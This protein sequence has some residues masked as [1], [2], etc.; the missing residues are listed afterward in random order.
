M[1]SSLLFLPKKNVIM[2]RCLVESWLGLLYEEWWQEEVG[3]GGI[4]Q[5]KD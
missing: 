4:G 5:W 1:W 3:G 2:N